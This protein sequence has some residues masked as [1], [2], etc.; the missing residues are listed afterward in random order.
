MPADSAPASAASIQ[1]RHRSLQL[2]GIFCGFTA[3]A[4]LGAAEA[5]TKLVTIGISPIVI[6]LIMVVGVF[7]ARW[8]LPALVLG[9]TSVRSDVARAP[10]L[11]IWALLAGC[12]WAVANTLTIFAIRDVGLSIAFPLWNSNSLLG[13]LWGFLFFNELRQAGWRRWAGVLGGALI[14]CVGA[15]ILA[16]ASSSQ[17]SSTHSLNGVWAALGAGVLW[18]TMYIPYRKAYLTGMNPLSF[19]T[20][21]TFGELGMMAALALTYNG[22]AP[23]W[24]ELILARTVI[25]WLMLGG[26]IW[27]IGDLFQQYAA[28]YVGIGRG[29]PLSNTNQ[30]WGLLWGIF[31]FGELHGKSHATYLQVIG[32]SLLMM[33]GVGAIA[34]SSATGQ[35]QMHWKEAAGRESTRYNVSADYVAARF[36]GRQAAGETT[37]RRTPLDWLLVATATAILVA[38]AAIARIPHLSFRWGPALILTSAILLLFLLCGRHLWRTTHFH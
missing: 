14:M 8:S 20:F 4:W 12:L 35:E 15:A 36:E 1:S 37:P 30:L 29:I 11:I 17:S 6:S 38:F 27:V 10:H 9:T 13:I 34:L 18:G 19:V 24:H 22:L 2:L 16:I 32:G 28:K 5:P 31:V 3:G 7:L 21:F 25:F 33:L 23:L 26:F